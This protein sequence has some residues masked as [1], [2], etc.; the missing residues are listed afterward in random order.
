MGAL[1]F[2]KAKQEDIEVSFQV[3]KS[4][5]ICIYI[6]LILNTHSNYLCIPQYFLLVTMA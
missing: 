6:S 3:H 1:V 4:R 2:W 5:F